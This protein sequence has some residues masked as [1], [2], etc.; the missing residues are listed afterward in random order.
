MG[1][2]SRKGPVKRAMTKVLAVEC[3]KQGSECVF[4]CFI[5]LE[6]RYETSRYRS[7]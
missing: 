5:V 1:D 3:L 2:T 7:T 4:A 6:S